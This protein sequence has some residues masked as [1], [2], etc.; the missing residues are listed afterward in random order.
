MVPRLFGGMAF[1][2]CAMAASVQTSSAAA[3]DAR[4]MPMRFELHQE[5]PLSTCGDH[6]RT[7]I[8]AVGSVTRESS[9]DFEAFVRKHPIQ[10]G[11]IAFNSSG[12]SVLGA[13]ALGRSIRRLGMA[14]TVGDTIALATTGSDDERAKLSPR[15]DCESMCAFLLLAGTQR[16]VPPEARVLV[17]EIWLGDRREDAAAASYTAED[18]AIVQRD[19]GQL[20]Q[21]TVEMGGSI[22][23]LETALRIPPWEPMRRLSDKELRRMG[24]NMVADAPSQESQAAAVLPAAAT[25][26]S[27]VPAT[28][29]RG[30]SATEKAG[31]TTLIRRHP[32]TLEGD[33]IGSFDLIIAC[34]S[35]PDSYDVTYVERRSGAVARPGPEPLKQVA[36]STGRRS[37][38]LEIIMSEARSKRPEIDSVARG[39]V[40]AALV[41]SLASEGSHSLTIATTNINNVETTI[42]MGN[43]G[44]AQNFPQFAASCSD[45]LMRRPAAHAELLGPKADATGSIA[46]AQ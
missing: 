12:G 8:S 38:P 33:E 6:C 42:R 2:F 17:H 41:R 21:Y 28:A 16:V 19:I 26:I 25:R 43:T 36:I 11:T 27:R 7:W 3:L 31:F 4:M 9:S 5:G 10:G 46:Q 15:A 35:T 39:I 14:T 37:V 24:L 32:L 18:L 29:E 23:L 13:L 34:A 1:A 20:A 45:Q 40:P 22:E 44:V 30:W